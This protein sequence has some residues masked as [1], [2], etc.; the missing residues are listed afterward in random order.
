MVA[1][2]MVQRLERHL[3]NA[4]T[5]LKYENYRLWFGGQL[6]SLVGTW[7][8]STAQAFLIFQLTKSAAYLGYV[9]FAGGIPAWLLMLYGGLVADRRRRRDLLIITQAAMMT[10]AF[11]LAALT[12]ARLV[13]PWQIV[14]LAFLLG[15]ANA[16][17]APARQAFVAELVDR[18][19][20][21][22]AIALNSTMFQ[23]ATVVGPAVAG[24][25]YAAFG[26]A[27][28]F[29]IN[30]LSFVAVI[31]ALLKMRTLP[32]SAR[33]RESSALHE[34]M[35]GVHY[36]ARHTIIRAVIALMGVAGLAGAGY[37]TLFPV[38]AVTILHGDAATNGWLQSARGFGALTGA[39]TIAALGRF[40]WKGRLL[41]LATFLF[42]ATLIIFAAV[43]S[44]PLSLLALVG[45]GWGFLV[46]ANM[47]GTLMQLLVPEELRGRVTGVYSL[48]VFGSLPIGQLAAGT[49]AGW[50][51]APVTVIAGSAVLLLSAAALYVGVP[52]LRRVQ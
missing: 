29:A 13:Q 25:T 17:D 52:D 5:A 32:V 35:D 33:R 49:A 37:Y 21:P 8:Q 19:D 40:Q 1:S 6:A 38:W 47:A 4:S 28:C 50:V 3:G 18:V 16:F 31:V 9:G 39:L 43:S 46:Q 26:P 48:V 34:M 15:I 11:V 14:L 36:A 51:G 22:N 23:L 42:P 44:L 7:M 2:Q 24:A 10:L 12:F 20:L 41:T 27:W 45:V 30:G